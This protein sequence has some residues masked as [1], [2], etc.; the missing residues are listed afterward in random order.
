MSYPPEFL[1]AL[2]ALKAGLEKG[3]LGHAYVVHGSPR[4][5]GGDFV[6]EFLSFL[7]GEPELV[8]QKRHPD[9][10]T[11]EPESKSRVVDVKQI[12]MM[13]GKLSQTS[14]SN[15]WKAGVVLYADRMNQN[16]ANA[17][18]KTLEE[19]SPRTLIFLVTEH[20]GS[21][22]PTIS[23]RC[24]SILLPRAGHANQAWW[25]EDLVELLRLGSA[26]NPVEAILLGQG[27][28]GLLK[29]IE[30]RARDEI[31]ESLQGEELNKETLE[32]RVSSR[33]LEEARQIMEL[34]LAWRRDLLVLT[35]GV[36]DGVSLEFE[37]ER[38]VLEAQAGELSALEAEKGV[39]RLD[40][41]LNLLERKFPPQAVF[42]MDGLAALLDAG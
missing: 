21:L 17:F 36:A 26:E 14:F 29:E 31:L 4:G 10:H 16:A 30:G 23:S 19:P 40:R 37:S 13:G 28:T 38:A 35:L 15:G 5:L 27:F 7:L 18:L 42:E 6:R 12:R 8:E 39:R 41:V 34:V 11:V 33:K 9:V 25:Y 22:L 3:R 1:K 20:G 32:A 2:D 24:Q